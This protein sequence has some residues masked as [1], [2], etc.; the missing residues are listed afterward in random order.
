MPHVFGHAT[1]LAVQALDESDFVAVGPR[2]AD[3]TG[4]RS[5]PEHR[6]AL[7]HLLDRFVRNWLLHP[8]EVFLRVRI[9]RPQNLIDR[10]AIVGQKQEPRRIFVQSPDRK[11]A[12]RIADVVHHIPTNAAI[13]GRCYPFWLV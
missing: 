1:D 11:N 9:A 3:I 8:D 4:K 6:N 2:A 5:G 7:S 13:C 10:I 12:F